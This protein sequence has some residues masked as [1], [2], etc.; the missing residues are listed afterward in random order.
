M[1]ALS[2]TGPGSAAIVEIDPPVLG[3]GEA[4]VAPR[5]V[6]LCGTDL[7]LLTGSMPYFAQGEASYPIQPGHEVTGLVVSSQD[8]RLAAGVPVLVDP[9]VGCG[10]CP[11]C[12]S[13]L[14]TRCAERRELG[15]RRGMPGGACELIAVPV[16]NLHPVPPGVSVRDAPLVEP[17]VTAFNAVQ[18]LGDVDDRRALVIGAGTLGL[19]A[20]QLL[21]TRGAEVDVAVAQPVRAALVDQLGARPVDRVKPA[22]YPAVIEAAGAPDAVRSAFAAVAPGGSVAL[23]GVQPGPVGQLD[24][25]D[26][27]LKDATA[28]GVLNGPGLFGRML[29]ELAAGTCDVSALIDSEFELA[30]ADAALAALAEP[31]RRAPKVLLRVGPV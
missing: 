25:N 7:E 4:L 19:I 3:T 27:V 5:Y 28:R 31:D 17:G 12:A 29:D 10:S 23:V 1:R 11:A 2:V 30:D 14:P 6:G 22:L 8:A 15:L 26:L 13:A 21:L 24:V 20:A 16:E 18:R 9:V